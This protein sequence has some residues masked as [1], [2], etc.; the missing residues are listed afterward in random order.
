MNFTLTFNCNVSC[1]GIYADVQWAE[2]TDQQLDNEQANIVTRQFNTAKDAK[3]LEELYQKIMADI[4]TEIQLVKGNS[5]NKKGKNL[6]RS[7]LQSLI[8]EYKDFK[9]NNVQHFR[10]NSASIDSMFGKVFGIYSP[11]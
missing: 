1:E 2:P 9:K 5:R 11:I 8:S 6:D 10:F 7:K 3:L 4:R